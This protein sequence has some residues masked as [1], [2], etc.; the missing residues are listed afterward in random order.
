MTPK[1]KAEEL[2][3]TIK[4]NTRISYKKNS[5]IVCEELIDQLTIIENKFIE[6]EM[7]S[8]ANH[9][10]GKIEYWQKVKLEIEKL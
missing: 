10:A 4:A 5:I 6:T 7:Y 3:G 2:S 9:V 8:C 1:N